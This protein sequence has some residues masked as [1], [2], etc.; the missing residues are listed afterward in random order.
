[1]INAGRFK[2]L[3]APADSGIL[4]IGTPS[5]EIDLNGVKK[6]R[7]VFQVSGLSGGE[8]IILRLEGMVDKIYFRSKEED[9]VVNQNGGYQIFFE[10]EDTVLSA[11]L[12]WVSKSGG[13]PAVKYAVMVA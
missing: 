2:G 6:V 5:E 9:L 10:P 11:R 3:G 7:G 12:L 4:T 8:N 1:M 13:T